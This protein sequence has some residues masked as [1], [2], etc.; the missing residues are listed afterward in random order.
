IDE[1][2]KAL[3][4]AEELLL[5]TDEDREGEA[6][7]WHL[8]EVL[9]PKVAVKRMVFHEITQTAIQ[10]ALEST[11]EINGN[12]VN[13]QEARRI[14][15]R[16]VGYP[17]SLLVSKKIARG[18]SAGRVQSPAVALLVRRERERRRFRT[19]TYWDLK[20][21]LAKGQQDFEA[22]LLRVDGTRIA[23]SKDFDEQTGTI[24][25][26]KNVLCLSEQQAKTFQEV[27]HKQPWTVLDVQHTPYKKSPKAPFTTSTLQQEASR[28]LS[29]SAK[30]TMAIAQRL[31]ENGHITYMRTDSVNLSHQAIQAA[32]SAI[33]KLY[34]EDFLPAQDR[35]YKSKSQ[36]AQEAH[37]AIRPT[38]D[39][40]TQPKHIN[41]QGKE[42]ALYDMIWKRTV[43][44]QMADAQ[45]T[46]TRVELETHYEE[47]QLLFRANGHY[48]NF[49]GYM[50]AYIEGAD[51]PQVAKENQEVHLPELHAGE[52]VT[53]NT[54][55]ALKHETKPPARFTEASLVKALEEEGIGRPS[56][57]ASILE[58]LKSGERYARKVGNALVPTYMA[59][60]VVGFLEKH[61]QDL[62]DLQFTA[63]MENQLDEI[64]RGELSKVEYLHTFY[65]SEHGFQEQIKDR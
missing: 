15:D 46:R 5:A 14:L 11:R 39:D 36:N 17:L 35:R 13:A 41:L 45:K 30:D 61:F 33:V 26:G 10:Q 60:A 1:L 54:L 18:L 56:T 29:L 64:S 20:A 2:K 57:Y 65:R 58:K 51:D 49:P 4:G 27:L 42:L 3:K 19:G 38:G 55:K 37:E 9:N 7:S 52:H 40:F 59:F 22:I 23:T 43:A 25:Q 21:S 12:L 24:A 47:K 8:H 62:V 63:R 31:Y 28:K 48:T 50:K 44:S 6:I 32:R 34:G 16:L 53:C